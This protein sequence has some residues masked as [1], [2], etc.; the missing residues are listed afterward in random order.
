MGAKEGRI[1]VS[2]SAGAD[3]LAGLRAGDR[4]LISGSFI[5]ARDAA[6]RR[7]QDNLEAT[8]RLDLDLDGAFIYYCGPCPGVGGMAVSSAGP[9]TSGRMDAYTGLMLGAGV[10]AM[11]GK[12]VRSPETASAMLRHGAVYLGA[13]GGA[14]AYL[15]ERVTA[16]ETVAYADL[17]S[18]AV[19]R[20]E[21]RDFP[22]VVLL[23]A[24]GGDLYAEAR[25]R[26]G[27]TPPDAPGGPLG[28]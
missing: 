9:T 21:V 26:Y 15:A 1:R 23:D 10:K 18:E 3:E 5:V 11:V 24:V 25:M 7:L 13:V 19:L 12:G 2:T 27:A 4:L 20:M 14:G 22:A 16:V 17:L 28:R 8:G 6:H